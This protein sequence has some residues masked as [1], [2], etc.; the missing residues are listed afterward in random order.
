MMKTSQS[1]F[2]LPL[3]GMLLVLLALVLSAGR[4]AYAQALPAAEAAPI[5]TGFALPTSLGSLQYGIS[6]SQSLVWGFYSNSGPSASTNLN[7]DL[8]YL[9]NSKQHPFS[10]VLSGG[11]SWSE[12]GQ[13]SYSYASV[14][15]SQVANF[16]RWNFVISDMISYLPG[17]P[18][19]GL[20]GVPGVGDLGVTPVQVG[21]DTGQGILTNYSSRITNSV[22]GTLSRALTGKTSINASGNYSIYRFLNS[23]TTSTT[24]SGAG[25]DSDSVGGGGGLNHQLNARTS[26][27][28]NYSYSSFSYPNNTFG[29][30]APSFNSQTASAFVS[31]QFTRRLSG[32]MSAGPQW[33]TVSTAGS[34]AA[35]SLFVSASTS[36]TA[37]NYLTNLSCTRSTNSGLGAV[38]GA[39][40]DSANFSV[41]HTFAAVWNAAATV[42]YA[43][44]S[45]LPG[46]NVP[47]FS[48]NTYVV[49]GQVSR[50]I[51]RSLSCYA[52]YTLEDQSVSATSTV[53]VFSGLSQVVGFGITFSPS[54]LH[55]GH[56]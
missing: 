36:Y 3:R 56:Q 18:V 25:L 12:S 32:S 42:S 37:K 19:A 1:D 16:G 34:S 50:A 11:R 13:S 40:S 53:D 5:S 28:A 51:A 10:A 33:T 52:S 21:T 48:G 31:H 45:N 4:P 24:S 14:G 20:S 23:P 2:S 7:G 8:A 38:G 46:P 27:G 9:S 29:V 44:S 55:L 26:Y 47:S 39:I 49:G 22:A 43:H 30:F 17:T 35:L 41:N 54:A 6:A 15:L